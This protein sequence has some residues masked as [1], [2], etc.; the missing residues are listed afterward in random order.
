MEQAKK[1][2]ETIEQWTDISKE[3]DLKKLA[4]MYIAKDVDRYIEK[5]Q[6]D[7]H[8]MAAT[9]HDRFE[10]IRTLLISVTREKEEYQARTQAL[11]RSIEQVKVGTVADLEKKGLK[12]LPLAEY[13]MLMQFDEDAKFTIKQLEAKLTKVSEENARLLKQLEDGAGVRRE[14]ETVILQVQKLKEMLIQREKELQEKSEELTSVCVR[15][16]EAETAVRENAAALMQLKNKCSTLELNERLFEN[17]FIQLKND[18]ERALKESEAARER[19]QAERDALVKRYK[20]LLTGQRQ[21]MQRLYENVTSTVKYMDSLGESAMIS[22]GL[23]E[24]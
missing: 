18:K 11:E 10:E 22:L 15:A 5:L 9:Y 12:A 4:G 1:V 8:N 13:Q 2:N 6:L 17:E 19:W 14:S 24:I 23:E 21:S 3:N 7:M 20:V 16:N